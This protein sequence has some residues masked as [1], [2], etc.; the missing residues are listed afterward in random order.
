MSR[1]S[2]FVS[3]R[4]SAAA[5]RAG[6]AVLLSSAAIWLGSPALATEPPAEGS[7]GAFPSRIV[8]LLTSGQPA[9]E[10]L[11]E[12]TWLASYSKDGDAHP[13]SVQLIA[14][15]S[16]ADL[17]ADHEGNSL[18]VD[19]YGYV[20]SQDGALVSH[21]SQN[22]SLLRGSDDIRLRTSGLR[23][24]QPLR[25][26]VGSHTIRLV[27]ENRDTR[28]YFFN[29]STVELSD[30]GSARPTLMPPLVRDF[31][32]TWVIASPTGGDTGLASVA[33]DGV[34][35]T[36]ATRMVVTR[37]E[38]DDMVIVGGAWTRDARITA[39][40][41]DRNGVTQAEPT[42]EITGELDHG[43]DYPKLFRATL[44]GVGLPADLYLLELVVNMPDTPRAAS[45][46]L[47]LVV[48]VQR[49]ERVWAHGA[50]LE[51]ELPAA[52]T[53]QLRADQ[54]GSIAAQTAALLL[55]GQ[56]GGEVAGSMIWSIRSEAPQD[57]LLEVPFFVELEGNSL[58]E[59][60]PGPI[61]NVG[62]FA[63]AISGEG[64]LVGHLAQGLSLDLRT[65]GDRLLA[66]GLKF[67]GLLRLPPGLHSLRLLARNQ[68]SDHV[69][70]TISQIEVPVIGQ[71][72]KTL[73]PPVFAEQASSWVLVKQSNLET[74]S[75]G[76]RLDG[77]LVLPA[78]RVVVESRA[79][80]RLVLGGAGWTGQTGV[81]A[82]VLDLQGRQVAAPMVTIGKGVGVPEGPVS[83]FEATLGAFDL[84]IGWY[85][86]EVILDDETSGARRVRHIPVAVLS[87]R[88][89]DVWASL[90]SASDTERQTRPG[91][92]GE[93]TEMADADIVASYLSI[94][95]RLAEGDG[96]GARDGLV[97]LE[98]AVL[99]GNPRSLAAL[100]RIERRVVRQL[101]ESD[102]GVVVPILL[103]HR[104]VFRQYLAVRDDRLA[105]H[106]WR[107]VAALAEDAPQTLRSGQWAG[108]AETLLVALAADLVRAS[109]VGSAIEL[110][111][112]AV[113][114]APQSHAALLGLGATYERTGDYG[115]ALSPLRQL[116][117]H[118]PESAEGALRLAINLARTGDPR[119]GLQIFKTL[120]SDPTPGWIQILAYQ[121]RARLL[122]AH[123]AEAL[124]RE[125]V[126]RFPSNQ[127][128][129]IQLASLL[130]RHGRALDAAALI[131]RL[132]SRAAVPETS[133][134]VRYLAW[135]A[136]GL[137]EEI[138]GYEHRAERETTALVAALDE[139]AAAQ[140]R[141]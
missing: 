95:R 74:G 115:E 21:F 78:A 112:H 5:S 66:S 127:A 111:E 24:I 107:L 119:E 31:A 37:G 133:P 80:T 29:E 72:G 128:L 20:F 45:R 94:L 6:I 40:V 33:V 73:L 43:V 86:L 14:E 50:L 137:E 91:S 4:H 83:F 131:D 136:L 108:F 2:R 16:G 97:E 26:P 22:H 67:A 54:L 30:P 36:P 102:A 19:V 56:R 99:A 7:R 61:L 88:T 104:D 140:E 124:L 57:G 32:D 117:R 101:S 77:D 123:S 35:F 120:T 129:Q 59:E 114:V 100:E 53:D 135:P 10:L 70:L 69:F 3:F 17:L 8:S 60:Q 64:R 46:A 96:Y 49:R 11:G 55:S 134:R 28:R 103:L 141:S 63:Y 90:D 110:L 9:G 105:D 41:I 65:H 27:I 51:T 42:I 68:D 109:Q 93:A 52:A 25:L 92:G 85:T 39:R 98:R 62:V 44:G 48:T 106:T 138:H 113:D 82:R 15:I 87:E 13:W 125:A 18:M 84:P 116:I 79:P 132:T 89:R 130:D 118:H 122:P 1:R 76:L 75:V 139:R 71:E 38:S 126:S 12:L 58:L 81:T 23:V 121:E 47:P 34:H